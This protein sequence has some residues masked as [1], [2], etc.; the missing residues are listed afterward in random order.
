MCKKL[1]FVLALVAMVSP[2]L[3]IQRGH[4]SEGAYPGDQILLK[5]DIDAQGNTGPN[6]TQAGWTAWEM[7][8]MY[9]DFGPV[10]KNFGY[11]TGMPLV[12]ID[13]VTKTGGAGKIS[14]SR[15]R[16]DGGDLTN[17]NDLTNV[18]SD[19]VYVK[20]TAAGMGKDY[21]KVSFNFGAAYADYEFD[22]TFFSWDP[23]FK[24]SGI[25]AF[26]GAGEQVD[27]KRVAWSTTNPA[28]YA[29]N[30]DPNGYGYP[31]TP[32]VPGVTESNMPAGL[33]AVSEIAL[34]QGTAP[35]L[36]AYDDAY[37]MLYSATLRARLDATGR[38]AFYGWADM[39]SQSGSQ[40]AALN[41]FMISIPEPATIALLGLGGLALIRRK[42]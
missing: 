5:V 38:I 19:L 36:S 33:L 13:G 9:G 6:D 21:L 2:A 27:S 20:H 37:G 31:A 28:T 35:W 42:R 39:L 25:A 18:L 34:E 12:Q 8:T 23:A 22:Y 14:G 1:I 16:V 26:G 15:D 40:H 10:A 17:P 3:A 29:D 11:G 24:G 32:Y 30:S 4:Y 7:P 41:G